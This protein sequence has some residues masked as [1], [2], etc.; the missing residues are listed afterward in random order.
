MRHAIALLA[1]NRPDYQREVWESVRAALPR[2]WDVFLFIDGLNDFDR[3]RFRANMVERRNRAI[4]V[5]NKIF[6]ATPLYLNSTNIGCPLQWGGVYGTLFDALEYDTVTIIED[7]LIV[8]PH[9]FANTGRML[10]LFK[11]EPRCG[12]V[13]V[14]GERQR[15]DHDPYLDCLTTCGHLWGITTWRDRWN[16]WRD[17]YYQFCHITQRFGQDDQPRIQDFYRTLGG[18]GN[19]SCVNDGALYQIM[20]KNG[21]IPVSTVANCARY[22]GVEGEYGF[23]EYYEERGYADMPFYTGEVFPK[24]PDEKFWR[25]ATERVREQY[26]FKKSTAS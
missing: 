13:G 17:D 7:D 5:A 4:Y 24:K 19:A 18:D 25:V 12:M 9:F 20:L 22:I 3:V 14:F 10:E 8:S 15:D 23:P 26:G 16:Q 11:G 6:P 1:W 2:G 21:Q